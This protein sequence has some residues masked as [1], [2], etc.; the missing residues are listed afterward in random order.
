M[1][2]KHALKRAWSLVV[3]EDGPSV[4]EYAVM[5]S[6]IVL[7]AAAAIQGIGDRM[8]NIYDIIHEAVPMGNASGG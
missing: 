7:V 2:V 6:L 1:L 4:T 3:S 5:L 8:Y